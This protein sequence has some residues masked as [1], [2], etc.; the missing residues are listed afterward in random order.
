VEP[1]KDKVKKHWRDLS[2][3][4]W[5][6]KDASADVLIG[7]IQPKITGWANYYKA[8]HSSEAFNRLDHLLYRRLT[9]WTKRKHSKRGIRWIN[10]KYF[11]IKRK[12]KSKEYTHS[13]IGGKKW[14]FRG[15][16]RHIKAYAKHKERIGSHARV[17]FDRSYYDGDVA[18][19]AER[20]SRGYGDISPS[21]AKLLRKQKGK[22]PHCQSALTND[23]LL[24]VHHRTYKSRGGTD[25]YP[26]L[27]LLHKHCHD[28]IHALDRKEKAGKRKENWNPNGYVDL[29]AIM[30]GE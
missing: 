26:N 5:K 2:D 13:I 14:V 30:G 8:A 25:K 18:Y 15:E 23:D 28:E 17:G 9:Q 3:T 22:C 10:E 1:T 11:G 16:H 4:I 12:G 24:H 6:L 27:V 7:V 21:K 29:R 20:L 19:W